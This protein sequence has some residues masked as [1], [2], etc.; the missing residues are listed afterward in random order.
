[1]KDELRMVYNK[2]NTFEIKN[3]KFLGI[4]SLTY[5]YDFKSEYSG[6][7]GLAPFQMSPANKELNFLW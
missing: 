5:T 1:M 3:V 4:D 7:I 6:Y 2:N